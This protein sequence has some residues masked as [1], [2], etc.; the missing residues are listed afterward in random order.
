MGNARLL[1]PGDNAAIATRNL[2]SFFRAPFN[3][4]PN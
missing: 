1:V 4:F 2:T 3:L